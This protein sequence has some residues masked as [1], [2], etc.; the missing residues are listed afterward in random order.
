[1]SQLSKPDCSSAPDAMALPIQLSL[2][3]S[4]PK[5]VAPAVA[6]VAAHKAG[7]MAS[8][9]AL[10]GDARPPGGSDVSRLPAPHSVAAQ[11]RRVAR[12]RHAARPPGGV[13]C[14]PTNTRARMFLRGQRVANS[15]PNNYRAAYRDPEGPGIDRTL[16]ND[17]GRHETPVFVFTPVLRKTDFL[18]TDKARIKKPESLKY[19]ARYGTNGEVH[20]SIRDILGPD[21]NPGFTVVPY[22]PINRG[23][24]VEIAE[25]YQNARGSVL[26]QYD[27]NSDGKGK[28][29]W[30]VLLEDTLR[31][32]DLPALTT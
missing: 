30:R 6:A 20:N 1:M 26:F 24:P 13:L 4:R 23:N 19:R 11:R 8:S 7:V 5:Y 18:P 9:A 15:L 12:A 14:R 17:K 29:R 16:F 31:F 3:Y 2:E 10:S 27:P 25:L 22:F 21:V 32:K 28:R